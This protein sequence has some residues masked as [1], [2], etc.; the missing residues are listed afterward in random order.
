[1]I[2]NPPSHFD[3]SARKGPRSLIGGFNTDAESSSIG[4]L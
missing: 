2:L 3:T 4:Y 1:M